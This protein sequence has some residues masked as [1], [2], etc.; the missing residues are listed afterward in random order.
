MSKDLQTIDME[1]KFRRIPIGL[2]KTQSKIMDILVEYE[3]RTLEW[4]PIDELTAKVYHPDLHR[5]TEWIMEDY[6]ITRSQINTVHR[7]VK[8]LEKGGLVK[9]MIRPVGTRAGWRH[10]KAIGIITWTLNRSQEIT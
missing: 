6:P 10:M 8:S 7:A 4:T 2:G 5:A 9:T 3:A 1:F